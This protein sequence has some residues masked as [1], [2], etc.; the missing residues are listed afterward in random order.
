MTKYFFILAIVPC[1]TLACEKEEE[2]EELGDF[3]SELEGA[4]LADSDFSVADGEMESISN[5]SLETKLRDL[6]F[7]YNNT[8]APVS[9]ALLGKEYNALMVQDEDECDSGVEN[10]KIRASDGVLSLGYELNFMNCPSF[11]D[12][13]NKDGTEIETATMRMFVQYKC[14]EGGLA[15]YNN[16]DPADLPDEIACNDREVLFNSA[17]DVAGTITQD[18]RTINMVTADRSMTGETAG[19]GCSITIAD[20]VGTVGDGCLDRALYATT[21]S[22]G[23]VV[24]KYFYD[25]H[26]LAT[27]SLKFNDNDT[28][29]YNSEGVISGR[30]GNWDGTVTYAG[31]TVAPAYVFSDVDGTYDDETGE[32][33]ASFGL[34]SMINT[35]KSP[36]GRLVSIRK[37]INR[38]RSRL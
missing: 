18:G 11:T 10:V 35:L 16:L 15:Q 26:N 19:L 7:L 36:N 20:G 3:A 24:A 29:H 33:A 6:S 21:S 2:E 32:L 25:Y 17:F 14:A 31:G 38:E 12:E 5:F 4:F 28:D 22:E 9:Q 13:V 1:F 30:V 37:M 23:P 27:T 34:K 8:E